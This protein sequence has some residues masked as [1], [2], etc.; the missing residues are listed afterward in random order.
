MELAQA[1]AFQIENIVDFVD[2]LHIRLDLGFLGGTIELASKR[3]N[4]EM[5]LLPFLETV[6]SNL[7]SFEHLIGLFGKFLRNFGS[8]CGFEGSLFAVDISRFL[9]TSDS[10]LVVA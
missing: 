3:R 2:K 4:L 10:S 6:V 9:T 8:I 5:Q 1:S 7:H